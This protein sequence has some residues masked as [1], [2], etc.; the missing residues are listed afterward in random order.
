MHQFSLYLPNNI[1][2]CSGCYQIVESSYNVTLEAHDNF[3]ANFEHFQNLT[4]MGVSQVVE[5]IRSMLEQHHQLATRTAAVEQN[6][7]SQLL[8]I[9]NQTIRMQHFSDMLVPEL[10]AVANSSQDVTMSHSN[11]VMN[12]T[13]LELLVNSISSIIANNIT[14]LLGQAEMAY[15][16]SITKVS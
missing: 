15:N 3:T 4:Q 7:T 11:N 9:Q 16:E 1:T 10:S 5:V 8:M 14:T 12:A 2:G 13:Q 6:V